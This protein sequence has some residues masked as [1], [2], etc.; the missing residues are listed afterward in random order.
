MKIVTW[1][2]NG[3]YGLGA[4]TPTKLLGY[5]NL[6]YFIGQLEN[7]DADVVCLQ[8]VH[9][10]N[11]RSQACEIA[12]A[13]G[14]ASIFQSAASESHLDSSFQLTN[15]ILAKRDFQ[16][17]RY[18]TLPRPHFLVELPVLASGKRAVIHDKVLQVVQLN[19][20]MVANTHLLPLHILGAS[21]NSVEGRELATVTAKSVEVELK[22]PVILCGDFNYSDV[23]DLMPSL[24]QKLCLTDALPDEPSQPHSETRI[25]HILV[26][27]GLRVYSSEVIECFA[28]HFPCTVVFDTPPAT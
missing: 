23:A 18:I 26:S 24:V 9:T 8:E 22:P 13:L 7:I 6:D 19:E 27:N 1:N 3:G 16:T 15:A 12:A 28:D 20:L 21:W 17:T 2:I 11:E 25:D 10:N 5:E 4:K 14:Y